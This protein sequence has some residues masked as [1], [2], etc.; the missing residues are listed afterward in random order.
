AAPDTL[1]FD[2]GV[3]SI[4]AAGSLG[5]SS[6][7]LV[8]GDN[9]FANLF[10]GTGSST[11]N[12]ANPT[13]INGGLGFASVIGGST[14]LNFTGTVSGDGSKDVVDI[15]N[16][17]LTT[18]SGNFYLGGSGS[19][20]VYVAG[21]GNLLVSAPIGDTPTGPGP[22]S[23][24]YEG[25]GTMT[26][27]NTN[28]FTGNLGVQ[29]GTVVINS[30]S[31]LGS[32]GSTLWLGPVNGGTP[33]ATSTLQDTGTSTLTIAHF[34]EVDTQVNGTVDFP[35]TL[36]GTA[37]L[38]FSNTVQIDTSS[39]T[40]NVIN[41]NNTGGVVLNGPLELTTGGTARSLTFGGTSNI[42]INGVVATGGAGTTNASVIY[43]G[44]GT[45][46]LSNANTY[47]GSTTVDSGELD[48]TN[49]SGSATSTANLT[50]NG[51]TLAS[52]SV[53]SVAGNVLTGGSASAY[54]VAPGGVGNVGTLTI[55]GLTSSTLTTLSFK[56]GAGSGTVTNGSQLILG[57]GTVSVA[58]GTNL[59]FTGTPVANDDY[60]IIGDTSGTG[61][62]VSQIS[63][64]DF[65]LPSAPAGLSY[66]LGYSSDFIDLD[67]T[68]SGP[69]SVTWNDASANNTWDK[70]SINWNNGSGNTTYADGDAVTFNDNN[71][72]N[73]GVTLNTTVAPSSITV[74]NGSGNYVISGTGNITGTTSI[75][76][77]GSDKLT[78]STSN[79]YTGGTKVTAGTLVV[80]AN[81]ALGNGAV[82]V[83]GGLLQ[84]GA[85]TGLA[86]MTSLSVSGTGLFDVNNNHVIISYGS[87]ANDPISSIAALL[88]AGYNGGLWNGAGAANGAIISTAAA[89]TSSSYG[90]GYADSADPGNPA[91]LSSNTIE[92]KYTLLGDA[93]LAGTVDVQ[94][95]GIL[96]ANFNKGVTGW[97]KGDFFYQNTV[98]VADFQALAANFNKGA[99][100]ADLG[101]PAIDN[102]AIVAF[103]Q[104]NGLM[105]DLTSVPEPASVGLLA[106]GAIGLLARRRRQS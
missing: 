41:V 67:V 74:N 21:T 28:S 15:N 95:F 51:G 78:L 8:L 23:L 63:L 13:T 19:R 88:K 31:A 105:A 101:S 46:A 22:C 58:S 6:N 99:N 50:M 93:T 5:S 62:V 16:T 42:T 59:A 106:V 61:A 57:S 69:A 86:N 83:T 9:D 35:T 33:T 104:A 98:D 25:T 72:S 34:V 80:G 100:G 49:T 10:E 36:A 24:D 97:D 29:S 55:G 4:A 3:L 48:V 82:T 90:L 40:G 47:S 18:F 53:G 79:S 7:V 84:L 70:T 92:I 75:T 96:A 66:S 20:T 2:S 68:S 37:P 85:S 102:P 87:P 103:A 11:I 89:A 45:M 32:A 94:D 73:Y 38:V 30:D 54:T 17:A 44:T 56:L 27:T 14:P 81:G 1:D 43:S 91:S 12:I 65:T 39:A 77:S 71:G 52:G 64:T 60:A 26:L 76:K